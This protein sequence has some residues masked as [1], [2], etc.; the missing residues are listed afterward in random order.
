M[1]NSL[2]TSTN[3]YRIDSLTGARFMAIMIILFSHFEFL[4]QYGL[5]GKVYWAFF[6]NPTMGV[7]FFFM[8]SGFGMML[9]SLRRDPHGTASIGGIS[10]LINFG[11]N[12]IKKIYPVYVVFLLSGIPYY[13]ISLN[14]EN[15]KALFNGIIKCV[16]QF[17]VDLTLLQSS[18]G[19]TG[20]SHSLNGVCWFLSALF[21]IYLVSPIIMKGIKR[22]VKT[23]KSCIIFLIICIIISYLLSIL[24][25]WIENQTF[26]N[27]LCYGSPYRRVFYV[28]PGMLLAKIYDIYKNDNSLRFPAFI[29]SGFL[30][31]TFF[32]FS[33]LWFFL[34]FSLQETLGHFSYVIDM[35][36]VSGDLFALAVNSGKISKF[37][38]NKRIVLLGEISMYI[39]LSHFNIRMY[40]DL[41]VRTL[42]L[43]SITV[44][45]IEVVTIIILTMVISFSIYHFR[46][47][48]KHTSNRR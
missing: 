4:Q 5:F 18:T 15:V 44:A 34:S 20:F 1:Q 12:H 37:F 31:Y 35:V 11:K 24:F 43:E 40:I 47:Y 13:L 2:Q 46:T 8:V 23:I 45:I 28:I 32:F 26:F 29:S 36:L 19:Y 25:S 33:I 21:C 7:D 42:H 14:I 22:Y 10:G 39:F 17:V 3:R 38:A 30:E 41:I 16:I 48:P 27:D 9:S 6:H